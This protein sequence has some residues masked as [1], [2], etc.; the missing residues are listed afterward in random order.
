MEYNKTLNLPKTN[1]S[2]RAN[3]PQREPEWLNHWNNIQLYNL[4]IE[5]NKNNPCFILHDGPP[6]ANGDIHLGHA[7]NKILKDV[8]VR[9]KF[10]NN[11]YA[12]Y[13]PGWDCHGLPT[14]QQVAKKLKIDRKTVSVAE[15]RKK[16][17]ELAAMYI[18]RQREQFIRLGVLGD[19][20][21]PYITMNVEYEIKEIKVFA[22]LFQ[23]GYLY[24]DFKT[25]LW[26]PT[27]ETS[28]ADAEIEYEMKQSHSIYVDFPLID[29]PNTS[30][31]VWTTTPWT[32]PG[33]KA[34]AVHPEGE[35]VFI[36]DGGKVR[37]V[38][39]NLVNSVE[40][41]FGKSLGEIVSSLS[42]S[43]LFGLSYKH[44]LNDRVFSIVTEEW[45][46]LEEGTGCV[47][48]APGHGDVDHLTG[49][50][51]NLELAS[52]IDEKGLF[53]SEAG[54]YEGMLY[55]NSEEVILNELREKNLLFYSGKITHQYP[56][57]WRCHKPVIYR[58]AR[59]WFID[60][61]K[62][63][64][65]AIESVNKVE[66]LPF[67]SK[68][69]I[70]SMLQNRP[71]WCLSRQRVWG[72][73]I[74]VFYCNDCGETIL[75]DDTLKHLIEIVEKNSF[76][77]WY[78][79]DIE[80]LYP[81]GLRCPKCN[82]D[83]I[84]KETDILDV[85][86]DSG[87]SHYSVLEERKELKWPAD[88]YLEGSDQHRGWFQT[89][90]LTSVPLKDRAPYDMVLTSGWIV[91]DKGRT[92]HK[93]LGNVISP[94]E[95]ISKYGAD[96]L[97]LALTGSDYSKDVSV[98]KEILEQFSDIYR[99]IRNTL[100]FIISNLYDFKEGDSIAYE[101]IGELNQWVLHRLNNLIK[102]INESFNEY[103]FHR[104]HHL[105]HD[106]CVKDLSAFYLD[107]IK[108]RLYVLHPNNP[109]R[110]A[111]QTTLYILLK[112]LTSLIAPI[113]VFTAEEVFIEL[114]NI[115]VDDKP[116]V[117]LSSFPKFNSIYDNQDLDVRF[118]QLLEIREIVNKELE[119]VRRDGK[120]G[121]SL[122]ASV[123]IKAKENIID[124]LKSF[125]NDNLDDLFIV[126]EVL[127]EKTDDELLEVEV[128]PSTGSKCERCWKWSSTCGVSQEHPT[129][130]QRC[131]EEVE[132]IISDTNS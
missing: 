75:N 55:K 118:Q 127:L 4:I 6:Y 110:R 21:N 93:S 52:P 71:D 46:S 83:N 8:I 32:L 1:F 37:V 16:C 28:L 128:K 29:K 10:M 26:C 114:K 87:V 99:K 57:C 100:R 7:L 24:R 42:G 48:V 131:V 65:K 102:E 41:V 85:W 120:L 68:N 112:E 129:L 79:W 92:M 98:S 12:P 82:S 125:N 76:D 89:S 61:G 77:V 22:E 116:S 54:P 94:E 70:E 34:V 31:L 64:D 15:W 43:E 63:R 35:Y 90:L 59:Q 115:A 97:R 101:D 3:L 50:K 106:F 103:K 113:L 81:K 95:I 44:P 84:G 74:P 56:H 126:S 17:R 111:A 80:N 25:V 19:W 18:D 47:H 39:K 91:D 104:F 5:K 132:K 72:V 13:V 69:R 78:E 121:G 66:W 51:Y 67:G 105:L 73:P 124:F 62:Y 49:K 23:K 2:M 45:V 30:V 60:V 122:E 9:Y 107:V 130:C 14:E 109:K 20:H 86:F 117:H 88:L 27:C 38:L 53:T 58:A 123:T 96:V 40:K 119:N 36:K 33:N 108:D 11:F